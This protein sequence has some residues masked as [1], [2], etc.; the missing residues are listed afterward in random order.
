MDVRKLFSIMAVAIMLT[1]MAFLAADP[2]YADGDGD[3]IPDYRDNCPTIF[4]P[5]Q[6]DLDGDG[7]GDVCDPD[8]DNDGVIDAVDNCIFD[9]NPDQADLDGDGIGS[10]CD[11]DEL[12]I[13]EI[14][15]DI[16]PGSSPNSINLGSQG[17][18]PI[19]I[20]STEDFDAT[21]IDPDTVELAGAEVAVRGKSNKFMSHM[22][23]VN[24]DGLLDLVVQVATA[25]LD[26]TSFQDG[27]AILTGETITGL[28]VQGTDEITIVPQNE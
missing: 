3:G 27:H 19:A 17:L 2:V 12:M 4:N 14:T 10:V 18:I 7:L 23:D 16:K 8:D 15:I 6:S 1:F 28:M 21:L 13:A 26:P 25:N 5:D 9:Y 20:L 22:E 24:G 11:P